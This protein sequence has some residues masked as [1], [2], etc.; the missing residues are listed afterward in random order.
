MR[1][2]PAS[3]TAG[4]NWK[5]NHPTSYLT[6]KFTRDAPTKKKTSPLAMNWT[7]SQ[8]SKKELVRR[9]FEER[10]AGGWVAGG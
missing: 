9:P 4:G 5:R 7:T 6:K 3:T 1:I 10:P 2:V 8:N